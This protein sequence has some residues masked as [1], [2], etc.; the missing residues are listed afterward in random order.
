MKTPIEQMLDTVVWTAGEAAPHA[1]D[2]LYATHEGVL[3]IGG[4][5]LRCYR[6]NNGQTV[7]DADDFRAFFGDLLGDLYS[8]IAAT[9]KRL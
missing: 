2:E 7:F 4:V 9:P 5:K 8:D 6:L 1:P 3:G